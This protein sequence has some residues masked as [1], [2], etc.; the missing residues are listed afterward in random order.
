MKDKNR[1]K[2]FNE[3]KNLISSEEEEA[4]GIF[5]ESDFQT[6]LAKRI[7]AEQ[8]K[9]ASL[10]VKLKK[11]VPVAALGFLLLSLAVLAVFNIFSLSPHRRNI[12]NISKFLQQ[13]LGYQNIMKDSMAVFP[14][15]EKYSELKWSI[16][17]VLFSLFHE[18]LSKEDLSNALSKVLTSSQAEKEEKGIPV[19]RKAI[20]S[21]K[22]KNLNQF[23]LRVLKKLKEV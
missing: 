5:R 3:I 8:K 18:G 19:E 13:S 6:R 22:G 21:E 15:E 16:E 10:F 4:L 20:D 7:E 9:E 1:E 17:R 12:K 14:Q 23:F 2:N 11:P